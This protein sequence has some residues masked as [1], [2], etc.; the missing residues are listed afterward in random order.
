MTT[1]YQIVPKGDGYFYIVKDSNGGHKLQPKGNSQIDTSAVFKS[2]KEAIE[3]IEKYL[4]SNEYE[5][6]KVILDEKYYD[7]K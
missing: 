4:N 7:I 3:Y 5:V 2:D 1:F 6:E